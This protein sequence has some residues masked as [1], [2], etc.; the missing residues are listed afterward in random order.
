MDMAQLEDLEWPDDEVMMRYTI[1]CTIPALLLPLVAAVTTAQSAARAASERSDA[2]RPTTSRSTTS[3]PD[4]ARAD[5]A[6]AHRSAL[7]Y[8]D[9]HAL[10]I[11]APAGWVLDTRSGQRQGLQ[12]VFYPQG[13]RWSKSPAVMY[14]QVVGRGREIRDLKGM[15]EF[16]QSRF[17]NSS[18]TAL[19]EEQPALPAGAGKKAI[20]RHF[21]GG[22]KGTIERVAYIEERTVIVMVVL[23]CRDAEAYQRSLSAFGQLVASYRFIADDQENILRAIEA[24]GR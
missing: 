16:D 19:V 9:R 24:A 20:V 5:S 7:I 22:A 17:R 11:Q 15:L 4:A 13:E 21:S 23:S 3:R 12:A 1:R 6:H 8:G 18:P 14:C 10:T 2:A